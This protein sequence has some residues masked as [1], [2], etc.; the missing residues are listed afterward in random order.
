MKPLSEVYWHSAAKR[1]SAAGSA[2]APTPPPHLL[3]CRDRILFF[4]GIKSRAINAALR[5]ATVVIGKKGKKEGGSLGSDLPSLS[6]GLV[7]LLFSPP[8]KRE[9]ILQ[10][11]NYGCCWFRCFSKVGHIPLATDW[12]GEGFKT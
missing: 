3:L 7:V 10:R 5:C 8:H 4:Q 9:K 1:R 2:A 6:L 12:I 11:V